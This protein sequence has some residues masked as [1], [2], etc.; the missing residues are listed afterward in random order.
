MHAAPGPMHLHTQPGS[1]TAQTRIR[2]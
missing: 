2:E 1:A